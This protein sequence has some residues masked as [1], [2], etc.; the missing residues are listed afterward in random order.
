MDSALI[1]TIIEMIIKYGPSAVVA[2]S[3]AIQ[4]DSEVTAEDIKKLFIDK[5]PEEYFK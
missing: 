4:D 5:D 1:L 3:G 2:I